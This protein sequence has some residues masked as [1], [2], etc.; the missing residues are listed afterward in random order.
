[1]SVKLLICCSIYLF[2]EGL[3]RL[4]EDNEKINVIGIAC[5]SNDLFQ[6]AQYQPDLFLVDDHCCNS[7]FEV[8]ANK[9]PVKVLLVTDDSDTFLTYGGLQ[10]LVAKGLAGIMTKNADSEMLEK[11]ILKVYSGDLWIDHKTIKKSICTPGGTKDDIRLTKKETE[12]LHYLCSGFT[13]KETAQK[14]CISVQ[15][16]KSHCNNLYKKFGVS[17]RLKLVLQAKERMSRNATI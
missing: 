11:A 10:G 15:T 17:S 16:V 3:K 7:V 12:I 14:L 13:N 1:M 8:S 2:G 9:E 5:N 4:L 6:M